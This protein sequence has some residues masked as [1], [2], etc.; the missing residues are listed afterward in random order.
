MTEFDKYVAAWWLNYFSITKLVVE[1]A[2]S[3]QK[4]SIELIKIYI[5]CFDYN[6]KKI[7][8]MVS[9]NG[10]L[11]LSDCLI[12]DVHE[13]HRQMHRRLQI[14]HARVG[15][16]GKPT[17][18][19]RCKYIKVCLFG[20]SDCYALWKAT[21]IGGR[22]RLAWRK[23]ERESFVSLNAAVSISPLTT[24]FPRRHPNAPPQSTTSSP[25]HGRD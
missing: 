4:L 7:R 10:G 22:R 5:V 19:W 16:S 9:K 12:G 21:V 13:S 8:K 17:K 1:D 24:Q 15:K 20:R 14:V 11:C 25:S 23:K 6:K 18:L 2:L 3:Y